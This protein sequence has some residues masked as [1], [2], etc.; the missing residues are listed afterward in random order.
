LKQQHSEKDKTFTV[1]IEGLSPGGITAFKAAWKLRALWPLKNQIVNCSNCTDCCCLTAG[2][3]HHSEKDK[4]FTV[5]IEGL[6]P[7]GTTAFVKAAL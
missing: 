3:Q 7:G 5:W 6:S 1:R 4:T 2:T